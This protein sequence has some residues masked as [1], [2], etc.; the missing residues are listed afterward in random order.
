M[1]SHNDSWLNVFGCWSHWLG[2]VWLLQNPEQS[3]IRPLCSLLTTFHLNKPLPWRPLSQRFI[4]Q[5]VSMFLVF[6]NQDETLGDDQ[7]RYNLYTI[8]LRL[9]HRPNGGVNRKTKSLQTRS[10]RTRDELYIYLQK[11]TKKRWTGR[12]MLVGLVVDISEWR[13]KI[14]QWEGRRRQFIISGWGLKYKESEIDD[15]NQVMR[16]LNFWKRVR[17]INSK[18]CWLMQL[19]QALTLTSSSSSLHLIYIS[20]SVSIWC[21]YIYI[22][23]R[24]S[25]LHFNTKKS[26]LFNIL[27]TNTNN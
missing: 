20:I 25:N 14:W 8:L 2:R 26:Q 16:C 13:R 19:V 5:R 9:L 27:K 23:I 11:G 3:S 12:D 17:R 22:Y 15:E 7:Q 18:S 21:A 10:N 4:I 24:E 6:T 1:A